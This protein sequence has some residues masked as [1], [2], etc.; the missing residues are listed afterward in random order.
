[1]SGYVLDTN[2]IALLLRNHEMVRARFDNELAS[3]AIILGC[4]VVWFEVRRGLL[5]QDARRQIHSFETL[6]G[7]IHVAGVY[8][9]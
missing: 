9:Y 8:P 2:I 7:G 1:V 3:G 5:A 4:P 6:F